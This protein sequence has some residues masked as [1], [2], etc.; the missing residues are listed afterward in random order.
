MERGYPKSGKG[1]MKKLIIAVT[2]AL[3]SLVA[4]EIAMKVVGIEPKALPLVDEETRA[5]LSVMF[6]S[7]K[8][9]QKHCEPPLNNATLATLNDG[10]R[11]MGAPRG[12]SDN[13]AGTELWIEQVQWSPDP[14]G[15]CAS[16][17]RLLQNELV[18]L[19]TLL[20]RY[21]P[22]TARAQ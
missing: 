9:Y 10:V 14:Q 12:N 5:Q 22:R 16:A 8:V 20:S 4:G 19:N 6:A 1:I 21:G 11:L 2:L 13:M 15:W 17:D 3:G 7:A 18:R